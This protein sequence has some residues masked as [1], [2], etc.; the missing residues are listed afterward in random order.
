MAIKDELRQALREATLQRDQKRLDVIRAVETEVTMARTGKG[1]EGEVDDALYIQIIGAYA[2][3]MDKAR[4]EYEGLAGDPARDMAEKLAWEVEYLSQWLPKQLT[5]EQ[6]RVL[7]Q[8]A[9]T[10][11]GVTD[12][13]QAGRVVGHLMKAHGKSVDGGLVNQLVRQLLT[14]P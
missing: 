1:F 14:P 8:E 9:L 7:V 12:P 13:K 2:K 11:L 3:R 5:P 4:K 6:T 10:E